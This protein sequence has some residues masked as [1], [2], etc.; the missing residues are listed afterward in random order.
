MTKRNKGHLIV[1]EGADQSGKSTQA[2]LLAAAL[3]RRGVS[4]LRM[5]EPGGTA[6]G[7]KIRD[8]L[9]NPAHRR[10]TPATE[11]FLYMASR[12]QL[13]AEK[14]RPALARTGMVLLDRY[15]YSSA[16]YQGYAGGIPPAEIFRMGRIATGGLAPDLVILLDVAPR[17]G[18]ARRKRRP[19]RIEKRGLSFQALV[20]NGY[21]TMARRE[22]RRFRVIPSGLSVK[23]TH[24]L[25]LDIVLRKFRSS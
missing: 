5:R 10:M 11:L 13:V 24:H 9:L 6:L 20:R 19:D 1:L 16:A 17:Q 25:V 15:L 2:R 21:L 23:K 7:E 22:P 14:I 12:A 3:R 8:I 4:V 18:L